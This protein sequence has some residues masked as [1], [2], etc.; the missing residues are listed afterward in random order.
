MPENYVTCRCQHCN[1]GIEFDA[2]GFEKG[3]ARTVECPH[4]KL[5]TLIFVPGPSGNP[6]Q[7]EAV[8]PGKANGDDCAQ[9]QPDAGRGATNRRTSILAVRIGLVLLLAFAVYVVAHQNLKI[10]NSSL[11]EWG[12]VGNK[13]S[14]NTDQT[15]HAVSGHC[16]IEGQVFVVTKGR[17]NIR[18]GGET[19]GIFTDSDVHK[20]SLWLEWSNQLAEAQSKVDK[21]W[22]SRSGTTEDPATLTFERDTLFDRLNWPNG[23]SAFNYSSIEKAVTDADG[24]FKVTVSKRTKPV[25]IVVSA[26]RQVM[27]E[28]EKYMWFESIDTDKD[29]VDVILSTQNELQTGL[30][31][32]FRSP[33]FDYAIGYGVKIN[34][35]REERKF[36]ESLKHVSDE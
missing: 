28:E 22:T 4:C 32:S 9:V 10:F 2:S 24:R 3:E 18:L 21:A 34:S 16:V 1:K 15:D 26:K 8:Q 27:D 14:E 31:E 6:R 25:W 7:A 11:D 23:A 12:K 30:L 35:E 29:T 20:S 17:D 36:R 13:P 33:I 19:V 5:E